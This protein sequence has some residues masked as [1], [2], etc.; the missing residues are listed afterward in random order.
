M[1]LFE[2]TASK[3]IENPSEEWIQEIVCNPNHPFWD[4]GPGGAL[5]YHLNESGHDNLLFI[6]LKGDLTQ[7]Y[8]KYEF[9]CKDRQLSEYWLSLRD[10]ERLSEVVEC[11]DEWLAS[12]GLFLEPDIAW[13]GVRHF[14]RTG[15]RS[16]EIE[17]IQPADLPE[18]EGNW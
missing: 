15:G 5:M 17:W 2:A 6:Q 7:V 12:D 10:R 18:G 13:I 9:A 14:M 1:I 4:E 16:E 11:A 3:K 8:L